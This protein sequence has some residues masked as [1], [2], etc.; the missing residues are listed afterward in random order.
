MKEISLARSLLASLHDINYHNTVPAKNSQK[1]YVTNSFYHLYNRGVEKR[2]IFID[3]QDYQVFLSYI[4]EYLTI[5]DEQTLR[6]RLADPKTSYKEKDKILKA[7]RMNNFSEEIS[8]VAYCLM[9]NHFHFLIKQKKEVAI[10][11]F[12]RSLGTRYTMYFNKK[13]K[14]VGSL[15]QGVYKAVLVNTDIQLLHLSRYIHRNPLELASQG[16]TLR[17]YGYQPT[18]LFEF[19]GKRNTPWIHP[20]DIL[21]FFSKTNL[22]LTYEDFM[23]QKEYDESAKELLIDEF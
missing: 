18:S 4:K 15:C 7:L 6:I 1:T 12:M 20:E 2:I 5:K 17:G 23:K 13:Y 16:E 22:K 10:D 8:L 11:G 21:V 14:R 9:P 3:E 19:L